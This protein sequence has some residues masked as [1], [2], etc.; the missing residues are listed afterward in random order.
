MSEGSVPS[1]PPGRHLSVRVI[2]ASNLSMAARNIRSANSSYPCTGVSSCVTEYKSQ[3]SRSFLGCPFL[4]PCTGVRSV[5]EKKD[6]GS[7]TGTQQPLSSSR[8]QRKS[9]P[10]YGQTATLRLLARRMHDE[11]P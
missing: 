1:L 6:L 7:S 4:V 8:A 10:S 11:I 9:H 3:G 5:T 2:M